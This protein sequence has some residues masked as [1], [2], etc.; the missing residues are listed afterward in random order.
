MSVK[1]DRILFYLQFARL[2]VVFSFSGDHRAV[3]DQW[4]T[5]A[6]RS[7]DPDG[8]FSFLKLASTG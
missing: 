1:K 7:C 6:N 2:T 8:F 4:I 3:K 5:A